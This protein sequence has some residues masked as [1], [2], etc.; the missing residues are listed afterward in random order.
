M[1]DFGAKSLQERHEAQWEE[2]AKLRMELSD[3]RRRAER[4]EGIVTSMVHELR[5]VLPSGYRGD[6]PVWACG[7][8]ADSVTDLR[9]TVD[10]LRDNAG[11]ASSVIS[12][13]QGTIED[14]A[15][16]MGRSQ[17]EV[18]CLRKWLRDAL[19]VDDEDIDTVVARMLA[20][21]AEPS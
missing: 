7:K 5:T 2:I 16:E 11:I 14:L 21:D 13:L 12:N 9:S 10:G 20:P 4:A 1:E 18:D 3:M 15:Q 19:A 6:N 8:L 17:S